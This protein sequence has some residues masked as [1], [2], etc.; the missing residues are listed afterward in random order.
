MDGLMLYQLLKEI[1]PVV[2]GGR[3][4]KIHQPL[5]HQ[6]Q[7]TIRSN[8]KNHVLLLSADPSYQRLHLSQSQL[9]NPTTPPN[10]CLALR[11]YLEGGI[12]DAI[13]QV[14]TDRWVQLKINRRDELGDQRLYTLVLELMGRYSNLILLDN[15][16]R[17]ISACKYVDEGKNRYRSI[18]IGDRYIAPPP[19]L[20]RS[21]AG[22]ST[23]ELDGLYQLHSPI[24]DPVR[25]LS[26][27]FEGI[28][29]TTAEEICA[30]AQK[31]GVNPAIALKAMRDR[32][33]EP[34]VYQVNHRFVPCPFPYTK[35]GKPY[36]T[37]DQLSQAF[38]WAMAQ[39]MQENYIRQAAG[40]MF[41]VLTTQLKRHQ[42]KLENLKKDLQA[43]D[44]LQEDQVKGE[45]LI[46]NLHLLKRGQESAEVL[47]YYHDNSLVTIDLDPQLSPSDNAQRYFKR[48]Q[49]KKSARVHLTRELDKANED[50]HYLEEVLEQVKEADQ[51]TLEE[52]KEE[53]IRED[54]L[55]EKR[56]KKKVRLPKSQPLT[57]TSPSGQLVRVGRN[58]RQNEE[59]SFKMARKDYW[60]FHVKDIPG[61]HVVLM[62]NEASEEDKLFC[63]QVAAYHSKAR[64]S[65]H[66]PVDYLMVKGLN[67]PVG[68]RPGF[69]TYRQQ[70]TLTVT[71]KIPTDNLPSRKG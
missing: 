8:R 3:I 47:D 21:F 22:L 49:K 19:S 56:H 46:A 10:F 17:I 67:K 33:L 5:T 42:R 63:C 37:F 15:K 13:E 66:V 26:Q 52:I 31:E 59:L 25:W 57:Y 68:G 1:S 14:G 39:Q 51:A 16:E 23:L 64:Y 48:Y 65:N 61:S 4:S 41:Q 44:N 35:L 18:E 27:T 43:T 28:S 71:P 40:Q 50:C 30:L 2:K 60:W 34:V 69:V 58:N 9:D 62:S 29:Q 7:L 70:K 12:L 36:K 45:L 55:K 11:K 38:E 53:L 24:T 20:K 32:P 6:I 54:Y